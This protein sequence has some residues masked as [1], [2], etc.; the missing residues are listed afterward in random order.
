MKEFEVHLAQAVSLESH[1]ALST[2]FRELALALQAQR[3]LS[4]HVYALGEVPEV[5]K[6]RGIDVTILN[7]SPYSPVGQVQYLRGLRRMLRRRLEGNGNE[8]IHCLY[9]NSSLAAAVAVKRGLRGSL[10]ILYDVRSP[11]IEMSQEKHLA[12]RVLG[13]FYREPLYAIERRLGAEVRTWSFITEGLRRWY[14][15]RVGFPHREVIVSPSGVNLAAFAGAKG[16]DLRAKYSLPE[17]STLVGYVGAVSSSR[18][19]ETLIGAMNLLGDETRETCLLIV[20]DGDDLHRLQAL[21]TRE[22]LSRRVKF[23]GRVAPNEVPN[24]IAGIDVGIS[25]LPDRFIFRVS[26]PLKIL[27]YRAAN[28]PVIASDINCH[29]RLAENLNLLLYKWNSPEDLARAIKAASR[30]TVA[31]SDLSWFSWASI[32]KGFAEQYRKMCRS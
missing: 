7:G 19:L 26:F 22:G 4:L 25:H 29:N 27:E 23:A 11:W 21:V 8:V 3:E 31:A 32:A 28:K 16:N 2:Y 1:L 15:T 30:S 17:G 18:H 10:R 14:E 13:P 12:L 20:G 5:F 24:H 9:P 6:R